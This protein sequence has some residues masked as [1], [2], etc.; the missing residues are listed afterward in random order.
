MNILNVPV[1]NLDFVPVEVSPTT[2]INMFTLQSRSGASFIVKEYPL[3]ANYWTVK[4]KSGIT[5]PANTT[6]KNSILCYVLPSIDSDVIEVV[7]VLI[8]K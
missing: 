4:E 1:T 8:N 7:G 6:G 5:L 2:I 3:C